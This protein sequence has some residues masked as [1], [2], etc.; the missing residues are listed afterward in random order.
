MADLTKAI[1]LDP[2]YASAYSGRAQLRISKDEYDK[3]LADVTKA[4]ELN[5]TN[6]IDYRQRAV[7][8]VKRREYTKVIADLEEAIRLDPKHVTDHSVLALLFAECSDP[9]C[10]DGGKAVMHAL[11]AIEL[12]GEDATLLSGLSAAYVAQKEFRKAIVA[13][14]KA[15]SLATEDQSPVF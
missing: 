2:Q 5:P 4:I 12:K 14:E 3:G 6:P 10:R 15:I 8:W 9:S 1:A 13:I 7:V 11:R